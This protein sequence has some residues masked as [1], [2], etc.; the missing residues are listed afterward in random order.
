MSELTPKEKEAL[1]RQATA[2]TSLKTGQ[3]PEPPLTKN[4]RKL[5]VDANVPFR[6]LKKTSRF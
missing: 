5:I 1:H 6:R 2:G 4:E 3:K